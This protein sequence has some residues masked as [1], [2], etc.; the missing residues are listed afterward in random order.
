MAEGLPWAKKQGKKEDEK[1]KKKHKKHG[2]EK[3]RKE[4]KFNETYKSSMA[5]ESSARG[6]FIESS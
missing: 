3:K 4:Q 2:K 5:G 6:D 1:R